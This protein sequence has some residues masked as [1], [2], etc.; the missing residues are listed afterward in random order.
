MLHILEYIHQYTLD[1]NI[2]FVT[3]SQQ[4]Y[5]NL[6]TLFVFSLSQR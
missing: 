3:L 5:E 1:K 6:I 2:I 4:N